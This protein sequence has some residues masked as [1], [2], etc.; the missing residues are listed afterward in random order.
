MHEE[1]WR[2]D[3]SPVNEQ[4]EPKF[5]SVKFGLN[6]NSWNRKKKNITGTLKIKIWCH[7]WAFFIIFL[8]LLRIRKEQLS[9]WALISALLGPI[10]KRQNPARSSTRPQI[11][12]E[13]VQIWKGCRYTHSLW[14]IKQVHTY[15]CAWSW[16]WTQWPYCYMQNQ[17]KKTKTIDIL[18]STCLFLVPSGLTAY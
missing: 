7:F 9:T 11:Q 12:R 13:V 1:T 18:G 16:G 4:H 15:L 10:F 2:A 5:F 14:W 8:S 3:L 17:K 6:T